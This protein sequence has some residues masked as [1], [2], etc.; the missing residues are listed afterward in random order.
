MKNII[1]IITV[2]LIFSMTSC[3]LFDAQEDTL[4]PQVGLIDIPNIDIQGDAFLVF[5]IRLAPFPPYEDAGAKAYLGPINVPSP[6][7]V[8]S[9][10]VVTGVEDVDTNSPGF[11]DIT[12]SITNTNI[13]DQEVTSTA[14][15]TVAV[16]NPDDDLSGNWTLVTENAG[17][18]GTGTNTNGDPGPQVITQLGIARF[19]IPSYFN[20]GL[21]SNIL[22]RSVELR[23]AGDLIIVP[24]HGS[25]FGINW[26]GIGAVVS[27]DPVTDQVTEFYFDWRSTTG[28]NGNAIMARNT[29]SR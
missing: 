12:Y 24:E 28:F 27:R 13:L 22:D 7:D 19:R 9:D 29:Y 11:Y 10:M 8:T 5:D 2:L 23:I 25:Q 4:N 26:T 17:W 18:N 3:E 1:K 21:A 15:R 16:T 6:K 20:G 14:T